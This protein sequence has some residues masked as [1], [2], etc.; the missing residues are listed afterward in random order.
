[1]I[2]GPIGQSDRRMTSRTYRPPLGPSPG[3]L[4]Y[5]NAS[6]CPLAGQTLRARSDSMQLWR[7]HGVARTTGRSNGV[8]GERGDNACCFGL[9]C[10]GDG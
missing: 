8:N 3:D 5:P 10:G 6:G 1:M 4:R 2:E 9:Q 7:L